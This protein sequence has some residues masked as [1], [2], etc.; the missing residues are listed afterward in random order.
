MKKIIIYTLL[1]VL[2]AASFSQQTTNNAPP[3]KIDYLK[4]SKNQKTA[5]WVLLGGG[6]GLTIAGVAIGANE[7][8]N[9]FVTIIVTGEQQS[10]STGAVMILAGG[11]T[12]LGSIPLFISGAK[13]KGRAMSASAGLKMEKSTMIQRST[14]VQ[15]SY[16]ALSLKISL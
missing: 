1:L 10:S 6:L 14:F 7:V 2:P 3:V 12:M 9:D 16:P 4:K 13:N 8:A 5:A 15:N 11:A